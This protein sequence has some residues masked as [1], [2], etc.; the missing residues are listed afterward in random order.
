VAAV[1]PDG[2]L[3]APPDSVTLHGQLA[4][5]DGRGMDLFDRKDQVAVIDAWRRTAEDGV[6]TLDV[7]LAVE[8]QP[9][10]RLSFYDCRAE[11][12]AYVVV[13]QTPDPE[14]LPLTALLGPVETA[15][16]VLARVTPGDRGLVAA[17]IHAAFDGA[18]GDLEVAIQG[19]DGRRCELTLRP[20]TAETDEVEGVILCVADVTDRSRLRAEL[21]HRADHDALSGCLNRAATLHALERALLGPSR[22]AVAFIDLDRFKAV[23]DEHGHAVG[24][25]LLRAT[26]DRLRAAV[27]DE[28]RVGRIGG[29]EFAVICPLSAGLDE[30]ELRL[31]MEAAVNGSLALGTRAIPLQASVGLATSRPGELDAEAVLGR[32]DGAMYEAKHRRSLLLGN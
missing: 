14:A 32:A 24:D 29:D 16:D 10:G 22:V 4:F 28:D 7:Q 30:R 2:M 27:R 21:E 18:P 13:L 20:M 23:N 1:T 5:A 9:P 19:D 3:A 26:A 15:A 12:G 17:A 31:R 11:H 25:Q 8:G 6:V